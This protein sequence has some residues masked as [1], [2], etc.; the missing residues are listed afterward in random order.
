MGKYYEENDNI[1]A[2]KHKGLLKETNKAALFDFNGFE[3]WIPKSL[4]NN[5][6]SKEI[7]IPEWF[8]DKLVEE[9]ADA[10]GVDVSEWEEG[11][12]T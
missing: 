3:K 5:V 2:M 11:V 7:E 8:Y 1:V 10:A 6:S 4:L 12:E 9:L